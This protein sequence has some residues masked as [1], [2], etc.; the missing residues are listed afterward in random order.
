MA[1]EQGKPVGREWELA[2]HELAERLGTPTADVR[3]VITDNRQLGVEQTDD[4]GVVTRDDDGY[5]GPD[6]KMQPH[7]SP[8]EVAE[9]SDMELDAPVLDAQE[10]EGMDDAQRIW[11]L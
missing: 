4:Q 2:S 8:L 5:V 10:R 11:E 6:G 3:E 1:N 9:R 7:Q